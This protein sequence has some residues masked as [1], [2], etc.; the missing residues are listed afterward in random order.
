MIKSYLLTTLLILF[1]ASL[2][3]A[4]QRAPEQASSPNNALTTSDEASFK[5]KLEDLS[6]RQ[7]RKLERRTERLKRWFGKNLSPQDSQ[8]TGAA[9]LGLAILLVGAIVAVLGFVGIG[10]ILIE[11]GL[12]VLVVGLAIWL[13]GLIL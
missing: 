13:I 5:A 12:V 4:G 7:K 10:S 1:S 11:L 6:E 3:F 9:R 2:T 8:D